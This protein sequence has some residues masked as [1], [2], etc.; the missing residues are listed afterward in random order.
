MAKISFQKTW[1]SF[2]RLCGIADK[3]KKLSELLELFL[4]IAEREAIVDRYHI[5]KALLT[6]EIT[7]REISKQYNISIAKITRGSNELKTISHGL[8][9]FLRENF[10]N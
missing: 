9:K 5:I 8:Q 6:E 3:E 7:Q 1:Q 4:T 10:G 2:L